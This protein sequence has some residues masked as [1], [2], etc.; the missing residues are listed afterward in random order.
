[1]SLFDPASEG[2]S[3]G[4]RASDVDLEPGEADSLLPR[5][6]SPESL[7]YDEEEPLSVYKTIHR[8]AF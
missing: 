7:E 8:Y 6:A 4:S 2:Y 1:M 5:P 3:F